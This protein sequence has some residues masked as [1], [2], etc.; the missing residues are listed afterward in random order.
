MGIP[1]Y[2]SKTMAKKLKEVIDGDF[3]YD[4]YETETQRWLLKVEPLKKRT[5][6]G[7][8]VKFEDIEQLIIKLTKKYGLAMQWISLTIID[9]EI[10]YFSVSILD[11]STHEWV[12]TLY[13]LSMYELFS[14]VALF[15][16]AYTRER[17]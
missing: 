5:P 2:R 7:K 11:K 4:D 1:M 13:G 3:R 10:P 9:D 12:K 6:E 16:F 14:K 8:K 15:M 17:S